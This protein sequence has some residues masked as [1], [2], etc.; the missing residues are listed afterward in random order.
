MWDTDHVELFL[1][2][3]DVLG[4]CFFEEDFR[5]SVGT[6]PSSVRSVCYFH[7][8]D[9]HLQSPIA[10]HGQVLRFFGALAIALL[11]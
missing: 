8:G 4:I 10:S 11:F 6:Y 1:W 9:S 3:V 2:G 7:D 5:E